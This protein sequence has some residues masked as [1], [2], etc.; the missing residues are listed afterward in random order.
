MISLSPL[1]APPS[2]YQGGGR[3]IPIGCLGLVGKA[4]KL[5]S[6]VVAQRDLRESMEASNNINI[7]GKGTARRRNVETIR[8]SNGGR[9]TSPANSE[10]SSS[11]LEGDLNSTNGM[12]GGGGTEEEASITEIALGPLI[13][14]SKDQRLTL[15]EEVVLL[16]LKDQQGYLSF[17]ND[18]ISYVLRGCIIMELAFR[19][20]IR[21]VREPNSSR[22]FSERLIEVVDNSPTGEVLLDEAL[23]LLKTERNSIAAWLDLL[24]GETWNPLKVGYQ[25]KQVRERI[26]KGLV[27][28]GVLRTE[29]H[30]FLL[31]DMATHPLSSIATKEDV[32]RRTVS[33]CLGRGP[34][35]SLR[36]IALVTSALTANVLENALNTLPYSDREVA[37][38][39]AEDL[40]RAYC[41][42]PERN[43]PLPPVNQI[44]AGVLCIFRGL[45]SLIY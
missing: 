11:L 17:L 44:V 10:A 19:R 27:D 39:R 25:L 7:G 24:S 5:D 2:T 45:D 43:V 31:F 22:P 16:G 4:T 21:T 30:S 36:A 32:L 34:V 35:P 29:K 15:M 38:S 41:N 28:K 14:S 13:V 6:M 12:G 9:T 18:S 23:K 1:S 8:N 40:L 42:P 33:T 3:S 37:F 20:R 26:A